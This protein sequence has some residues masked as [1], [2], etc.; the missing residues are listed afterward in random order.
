MVLRHKGEIYLG[1]CASLVGERLT[2]FRRHVVWFRWSINQKVGEQSSE[3]VEKRDWLEVSWEA[4]LWFGVDDGCLFIPREWEWRSWEMSHANRSANSWGKSD[5]IGDPQNLPCKIERKA[6]KSKELRSQPQKKYTVF[7]YCD[8]H[9]CPNRE[10]NAQQGELAPDEKNTRKY[11]TNWQFQIFCLLW[12]P[13]VSAIQR[14]FPPLR[15]LLTMQTLRSWISSRRYMPWP[16]FC[17][18]DS[19]V[20]HDFLIKCHYFTTIEVRTGYPTRSLTLIPELPVSSLGLQRGDQI[21]VNEASAQLESPLPTRGA[22]LIPVLP[23]SS[24]LGPVSHPP[25]R[26]PTSSGPEFVEVD[27]SYLVHRVRS[28]SISK[29]AF[30]T[31]PQVVPDDN[32]CLFSSVALA[33]EQNI[34]KAPLIRKSLSN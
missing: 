11:M 31:Q 12:L 9:L 27:G 20:S 26:A 1:G 4:G 33:F 32:S 16:I 13:F 18:Q 5:D 10:I 24:Q 23:A 22:P 17:L 2:T 34:A 15:S 3:I 19:C 21:I 30:L 29:S 25:V 28:A 14:V 7:Q 8:Q 6:V